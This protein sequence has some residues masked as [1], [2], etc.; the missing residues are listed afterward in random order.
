MRNGYLI[1]AVAALVCLLSAATFAVAQQ[2]RQSVSAAPPDPCRQGAAL[3]FRRMN[4][5]IGGLRAY[6]N[7]VRPG[8]SVEFTTQPNPGDHS[9]QGAAVDGY[10]HL[11]EELDNLKEWGASQ[12][13]PKP[14]SVISVIRDAQ[15]KLTDLSR[16]TER[17]AALNALNALSRSVT[18][19]QNDLDNGRRGGRRFKKSTGVSN[20]S[21]PPKRH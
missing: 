1:K 8:E 18:R 10:R 4:A 16:S 13:D 17:R 19:L 9:P 12:S 3:C 14:A 20:S 7:Q 15:D 11:R 6:L 2:V 21:T 5:Q